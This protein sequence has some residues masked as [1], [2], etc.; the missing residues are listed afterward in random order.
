MPGAYSV[1]FIL[2]NTQPNGKVLEHV[3]RLLPTW[4][5]QGLDTQAKKKKKKLYFLE[6]GV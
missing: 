2:A 5:L 6:G 3:Y 4:R 1:M